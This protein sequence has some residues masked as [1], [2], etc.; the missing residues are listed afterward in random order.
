MRLDPAMSI[1]KGGEAD[2]FDIG[3]GE[4]A[5]IFKP[6]DHPDYENQPNEQSGARARI[7]EHQTKLPDFPQGLPVRV[8]VPEE[9]ATDMSR[10]IVGYSMRFL[11]GMETL[12]LLSDKRFRQAGVPN[13]HVVAIFR[14]MQATV[15][16]IH[17]HAV[18][19]D[20]N[21]LNVLF[22]GNEAHFI[23]ADS[24]QFGRYPCR[25]FTARFVDPLLCDPKLNRLMLIKPYTANSDWYA[26]T[27]MLMQCLLFVD[28]Y[29]GTYRPAKKHNQIPHPA[30]PL[31][32]ITVFH[33]EVIYPKP[34]IPFKVLPDDM[35]QH[36]HMTF[37]RD[38]RGV[39][40]LNLL[41]SLRWT[42]CTTCGTVHARNVCPECAQAAPAAVKEVVTVRGKVTATRIFRTSGIILFAAVQ[43]GKLNWLYHH[44]GKFRR[45]AEGGEELVVA[46]GELNPKMRFR[47]RGNDTLIGQDDRLLVLNPGKPSRVVGVESFGTLPIFDANEN[48]IFW[49][50]NGQLLRDEGPD[51]FYI[52][53][54]LSGQTLFWVGP[55]FG[56]GFYRAGN[57]SVSFVFNAKARGI[58]DNIKPPTLRGQLVDSTCL[59]SKS[60]CWFLA[61]TQ[62]GGSKV[63]RCT[64]IMPDGNIDAVAEAEEGDGSWLSG[65]R[66]KTAA[67]NFLLA[68][69]DDGIVRVEPENG[70]VVVTKEF[71]DTEP[72]V[73][74]RSH[75]F[76]GRGCLFAVSGREICSLKI[77]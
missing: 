48:H 15:D 24:F 35:L 36:F 21:D 49:V 6:P 17:K 13:E 53:D 38:W 60:H 69:T 72:F 65:I 20:F 67:A 51:Q 61:T 52:G 62:E 25:V 10:R 77:T 44:D 59:F 14:D 66:G 28:P 43:G 76:V 18:I 19:G 9:L 70:A 31:H 42:K 4:A 8:V 12:L 41:D 3:G 32:R 11:R 71:P 74:S 54:T 30:R 40:P 46:P 23:D 64:V 47:L 29:G 75:L 55:E 34:A 56:F 50:E 37:E 22:S 39:F 1:G 63:N 27:V 2:V 26:F 73:D 7:Q 16:G 68:S 57:V 58:K 5:K 33:P 45:M